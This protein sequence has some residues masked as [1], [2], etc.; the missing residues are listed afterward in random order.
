VCACVCVCVCVFVSQPT[1][2][3]AR[4]HTVTH[5]HIFPILVAY[6]V[7]MWGARGVVARVLLMYLKIHEIPLSTV[8][9]GFVLFREPGFWDGTCIME[10][11][12]SS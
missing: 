5:M 10:Q 8:S 7:G 9:D 4:K 1:H 11:G 12:F 2:M 3:C 6:C